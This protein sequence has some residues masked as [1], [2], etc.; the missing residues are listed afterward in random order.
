MHDTVLGFWRLEPLN[1]N[2]NDLQQIRFD[3]VIEPTL[4]DVVM[5]IYELMETHVQSRLLVSRN[6]DS[7]EEQ[8]A[9]QMI[10]TDTKFAKRIQQ[11]TEEYEEFKDRSIQAFYFSEA[12][13]GFTFAILLDGYNPHTVGGSSWHSR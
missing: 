12:W 1:R 10:L 9:F 4:N 5:Q 7:D 8:R 11:A 2:L 3:D 13:I 6:G